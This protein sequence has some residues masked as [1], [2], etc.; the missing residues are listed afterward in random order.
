MHGMGTTPETQARIG[1]AVLRLDAWLDTMRAPDGYGGPVAHWWQDCLHFTGAGLD[2][3]YEGIVIGYLNL[4]QCIGDER[5]L[6]KARR[7]GDDLVRG[8]LPGGN[9]R[10]SSFELNPHLGGTPHEAACDLALLHLTKA[11]REQEDNAWKRYA[12]AAARNLNAYHLGKLWHD[13][14]QGFGNS[15]DNSTFTPN[16]SA[17]IVEALFAL[18]ALQQ[19][20]ELVERYALPTLDT[21]LWHQVDAPGHRLDGAIDQSSLAGKKASRFFP[22]YNARCIPALLKGYECTQR[23]RYLDAARRTI[24]FISRYRLPDGSFPQVIYGNG[25]VNRYPQWI[26]GVGD[27]LRAMDLVSVAGRNGP[28]NDTLAWM[29]NGQHESGGVRTARGFA[30][31]VSQKEPARLPEFRDVLPVCGWVDKAFRYLTSRVQDNLEPGNATIS[32]T[33]LTC[34]FGNR[35][36][37]YREDATAIELWQEG[38]L[39][40]RYRKAS[41]WAETCIPGGGTK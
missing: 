26:A 30:A 38:E 34:V 12:L 14:V 23:E 36:A 8:Q 15:P 9:F 17:T 33:D 32:G 11:L 29:L 21:I 27:I 40:C 2:W 18:A 1:E 25:R 19:D 37:K 31:Q 10:N 5:W 13:E 7:A 41:A 16:K 39:I 28:G 22:F 24:S 35:I 4:Y 6:A 3:R 20:E